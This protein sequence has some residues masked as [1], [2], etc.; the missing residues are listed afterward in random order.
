MAPKVTVI[1]I[2]PWM[3]QNGESEK[4]AFPS[5][6]YSRS[7]FWILGGN[8][9]GSRE[10]GQA[11]VLEKGWEGT[12]LGQKTVTIS[13]SGYSRTESPVHTSLFLFQK[14]PC[15]HCEIRNSSNSHGFFQA[16]DP[17][18]SGYL[19]LLGVTINH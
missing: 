11:S 19:I 10:G 6:S 8:C 5:D 3:G 17:P 1:N 14:Q 12:H 9:E 15:F 18:G 2:F 4:L 16:H 13:H 7:D